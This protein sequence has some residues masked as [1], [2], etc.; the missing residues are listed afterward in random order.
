LILAAPATDE[1]KEGKGA[2]DFAR[3]ER[4]RGEGAEGKVPEGKWRHERSILMSSRFKTYLEMT[5]FAPTGATGGKARLS[6]TAAA[7][8]AAGRGAT[9]QGRRPPQLT[10]LH[11]SDVDASRPRDLNF[12][13]FLSSPSLRCHRVCRS[14]GASLHRAATSSPIFATVPAP[15]WCAGSTNAERRGAPKAY[16]TPVGNDFGY[17]EEILFRRPVRTP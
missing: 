2:R 15:R 7:G 10:E 14:N 12:L 6:A 16:K 11:I 8:E 9:G 13:S 1:S 3:G 17:F 4:C 5:Y